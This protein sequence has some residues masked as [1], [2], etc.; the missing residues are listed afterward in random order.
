MYKNILCAI[1]ATPESRKIL[2]HANAI[3]EQN[4]ARLSVV[5]TMEYSLLPRDYQKK[6]KEEVLP[7][8]NKMI[9][10]YNVPKNRRFLK[11]GKPHTVICDLAKAKSFDLIIVG[12]HGKHRIHNML[13]S[14][15][16]GIAQHAN[17]DTLLVRL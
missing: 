1:D 5:H 14:T 17:C 6:I 12:S 2:Q 7:K 16:N 11:F 8:I 15:A 4:N 10:K 13:G 9:D 3:A